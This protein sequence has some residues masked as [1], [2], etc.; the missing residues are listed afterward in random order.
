MEINSFIFPQLY[1][2]IID[3]QNGIYLRVQ[4]DDLI[5]VYI[6]TGTIINSMVSVTESGGI[7]INLKGFLSLNSI[8]VTVLFQEQP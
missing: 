2:G 7:S 8:A 1:W 4:C 3:K 5:D 6:A